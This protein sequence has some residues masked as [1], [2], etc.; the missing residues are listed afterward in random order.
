MHLLPL[1]SLSANSYWLNRIFTLLRLHSKPFLGRPQTLQSHVPAALCW[2]QFVAVNS[3]HA[4]EIFLAHTRYCNGK[5]ADA[6]II[7]KVKLGKGIKFNSH[8]PVHARSCN[9]S[10]KASDA[11]IPLKDKLCK[12]RGRKRARERERFDTD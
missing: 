9:H 6:W 5:V 8:V 2:L 4:F 7:L 11:E 3:I 10:R 12:G 1:I